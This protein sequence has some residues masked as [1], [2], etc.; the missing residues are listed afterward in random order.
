MRILE[1]VGLT[2]RFKGLTALDAVSFTAEEGQILGLVGPK[3]AG[4]TTCLH[5]LSGVVP[6]DGG[7]I[8][9]DG[10][11]ITGESA[12][13]FLRAGIARTFPIAKP[14]RTLTAAEH[15]MVALGP[16]RYRGVIWLLGPRRRRDARGRALDLL[17]SVG[18]AGEADRTP[19][20]L[21]LG[22][23][24]RLEVA[25][26][27]ALEPRLILLDEPL[28]GLPREDRREAAAVIAGLRARGLTVILAEREMNI[29]MAL[30]DRVV[31]LRHGALIA[32]GPP[33]R[34][35]AASRAIEAYDVLSEGMQI[36][37]DIRPPA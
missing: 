18:L 17:E 24:K 15:V 10:R 3:G 22:M 13:R 37:S 6:P 7:R 23:Q 14:F 9:F 30:A 1:V 32:S 20:S 33:E 34:V 5:C 31:V 21:T 16:R 4:K 26:A 29:E 27:L 19:E 36:E 12:D 2:K 8:I 28:G 35:R 11:E 25:R